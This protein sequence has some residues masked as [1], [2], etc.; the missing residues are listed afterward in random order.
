AVFHPGCPSRGKGAGEGPSPAVHLTRDRA[1]GDWGVAWP[2]DH[3]VIHLPAS[4]RNG[5]IRTHPP[6][7]LHWLAG[8]GR[9]KVHR[10][11]HISSS[12]D[13]APGIANSARAPVG[14]ERI[15]EPS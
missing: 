3:D 2:V 5:V 10:G 6:A 12:G 7:Q 14:Q 4:M 15:G 11:R 8:S 1:G 13:T 9:S